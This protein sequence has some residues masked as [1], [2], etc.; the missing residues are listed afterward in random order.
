MVASLREAPAAEVPEVPAV[1][2]ETTASEATEAMV[3][4]P[5]KA[6]AVTRTLLFERSPSD[7]DLEEESGAHMVGYKE[8]KL[9]EKK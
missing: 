5:L 7:E 6:M 4:A 9:E 3:T 2:I 1:L 8:V